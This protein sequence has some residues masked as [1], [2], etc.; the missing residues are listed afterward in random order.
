[1]TDKREK[2]VWLF[3]S[4]LLVILFLLSSTDLIIKEQK[5]EVYAISVIVEDER[6]D[7]YVNFKK[8]VDY[9]AIEMHA[10]VSFIT[11]YNSGDSSQQ[12]NLLLREQQDGAQALIISPVKKKD[13][14]DAM[15]DGR[16]RRPVV[17]INSELTGS[18]AAASI[19]P[20]YFDMGVQLVTKAVAEQPEDYELL[21]IS[22]QPQNEVT[23][24]F[25]AGVVFAANEAQMS[26]WE[27]GE[28]GVD[29]Y[30]E[31]IAAVSRSNKNTVIICL[32]QESLM[33][34][35]AIIA[36]NPE[37][38]QYILGVYGRGSSIAVLNYL[39]KG[40]ITGVMASDEFSAG[41][42]SVRSAVEAIADQ[43]YSGP[44]AVDSFYIRKEDLTKPEYEK[45]L[46]PMD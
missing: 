1:M 40:V 9:A 33:A 2:I 44:V 36:E 23:M 39:D 41:Y 14:A 38:N 20:D 5:N 6:D 22:A 34:T 35:A 13:M 25:Y 15:D 46:Y 21:L 37:L 26:Y 16:I 7:N 31:M 30:P 3:F 45:K 28:L 19:T 18:T 43:K 29:R 4:L 32:D 8:G 42:H 24:Q 27:S 17:F 10:D 11:L 12:V